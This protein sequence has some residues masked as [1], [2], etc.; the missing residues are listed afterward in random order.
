[1]V[2]KTPVSKSGKQWKTPTRG[3]REVHC[4]Y[5]AVSLTCCFT[6]VTCQGG[7]ALL[8]PQQALHSSTTHSSTTRAH[9]NLQYGL[10]QPDGRFAREIVAFSLYLRPDGSCIRLNILSPALCP[11]SH[12]RPGYCGGS[13]PCQ[14]GSVPPRTHSLFLEIKIKNKK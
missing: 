4:C 3:A 8:H 12:E 11:I 10:H 1:M 13:G 14:C 5:L 6:R 2:L 9:W 7:K